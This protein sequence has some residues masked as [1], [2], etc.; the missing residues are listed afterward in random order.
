MEEEKAG[1]VMRRGQKRIG[2]SVTEYSPRIDCN[3]GSLPGPALV[4]KSDPPPAVT[5]A[6]G[7]LKSNKDVSTSVQALYGNAPQSGYQ[8]T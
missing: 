5:D 8:R 2:E 4:V 6:F 1:E 3:H 7:N